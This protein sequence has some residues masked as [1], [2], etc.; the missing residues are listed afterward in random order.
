MQNVIT[1]H[2]DKEGGPFYPQLLQ[3]KYHSLNCSGTT[4]PADY[5]VHAAVHTD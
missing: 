3:N 2:S 1:N 5:K 4:K